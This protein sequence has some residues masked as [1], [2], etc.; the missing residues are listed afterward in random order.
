M[1]VLFPR[2]SVCG[3]TD[4]SCDI[5]ASVLS[6]SSRLSRLDL[7]RNSLCDSGV[8]LFSGGMKHSRCR[9]AYLGSAFYNI[10]KS[11]S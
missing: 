6:E 3:L 8:R 1:S 5:L 10:L 7:S 4:K 11:V 9:L 2:L